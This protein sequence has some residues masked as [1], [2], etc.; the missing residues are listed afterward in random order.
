MEV[1]REIIKPVN[2]TVTIKLPESFGTKEV[3]VIVFPVSEKTSNISKKFDPTK[4]CG[5]WLDKNM[6]VEKMCKEMRQEWEKSF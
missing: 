2:R 3:E 4:Y 6:D 1:I 5:I